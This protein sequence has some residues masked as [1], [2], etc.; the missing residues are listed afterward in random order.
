VTA[1][2]GLIYQH[3]VAGTALEDIRNAAGVNNS[4]LYHYFTDKT[5][6][7]RAVIAYQGERVVGAQE[8]LLSRLD[9]F[10]ALQAWRDHIVDVTSRPEGQHGCPIG[11]LASELADADEGARDALVAY[12]GRWEAAIRDGLA[13]MRARGQLRQDADPD[14]LALATLAALQGGLLLTH[15]R[16]DGAPVQ[17]A[18][19]AAIAYIRTFAP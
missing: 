8:R 16:R 10:A 6:L 15:T 18:L 12:F 17:A 7:V 13:T 9:S 3:N 1:A 19:D 14:Q 4:Q 2:A 11:T 5:H